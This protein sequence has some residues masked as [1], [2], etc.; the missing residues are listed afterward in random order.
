MPY[1]FSE[2]QP[3]PRF[4]PDRPKPDVLI[5]PP[6]PTIRR[7]RRREDDEQERVFEQLP[8]NFEIPEFVIDIEG[9]PRSNRGRASK[10]DKRINNNLRLRF[11]TQNR[12]QGRRYWENKPRKD[13]KKKGAQ[14]YVAMLNMVTRT[15]G[16]VS[17]IM[18]FWNAFKWN[19][20]IYSHIDLVVPSLREGYYR[21]HVFPGQRLGELPFRAQTRVLEKIILGEVEYRINTE[22]LALDLLRMQLTDLAYRS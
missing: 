3:S 18:D 14:L 19:L 9:I 4:Y 15:F 1:S 22:T 10:E 8:D 16:T 6:R 13:T 7:T 20:Y 17:E 2:R 12:H 11:R 5:P 21:V